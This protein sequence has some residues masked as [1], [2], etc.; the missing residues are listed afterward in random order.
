[1]IRALMLDQALSDFE[2]IVDFLESAEPG[3]GHRFSQEVLR[4]TDRI[5]R[6]PR[7]YARTLRNFRICP[8][9]RFKYGM[10]YRV[11]RR[12][13]FVH[14]IVDLRRDPRFIRRRLQ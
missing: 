8:L 7:L 12:F 1:M 13:I 11:S 5:E 2:E 14:T 9:G 4:A 3:L 6:F 10:F